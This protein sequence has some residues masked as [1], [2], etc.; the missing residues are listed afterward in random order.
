MTTLTEMSKTPTL[1]LRARL[2]RADFSLDVDLHL[3]MRGVTALFGASGSGKTTCLRVLAGLEPKARGRVALGQQVWQDSDQGVFVPTHQ[4][5][6]GYVFQEATLFD[7]LTVEGNLRFGFDRTPQHERRNS[8]DHG[9]VL[10]GIA[11]LL[12]RHPSELSGGERQRV[13]IARALATGP[14]LLLMDE[15]LASLDAARKAEILPWLEQ[16]HNQLDIPVVYVTHSIDE[17]VRLAD[18]LV[19]LEQGRRLASGPVIDLLA[20]PDLPWSQGDQVSAVI[21]AQ[22]DAEQASPDLCA[23]SF[24]AGR[25]V[26]PQDPNQPRAS[27]QR[28]RLRIQARD[29]SLALVRTEQTSVLNILPATLVGLHDEGQGQFIARLELRQGAH[30]A[31]LLARISAHSVGRLGLVPGSAVFAQVKGVAMVR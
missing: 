31:P 12:K 15:P 30:T 1:A 22:V 11:H 3:P 29:V 13:A 14:R 23:L 10:L 24:A 19:L 26:L 17:V 25:L 20:R 5:P 27:G 28:V 8:W 4:R 21:D 7:H 9:L 6:I 18:H 16:L 2:E